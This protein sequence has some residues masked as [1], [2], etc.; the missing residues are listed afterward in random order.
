[1]NR[2]EV[3]SV[4]RW[5][6]FPDPRISS[7]VIKPR[8]FV[9]LG[10]TGALSQVKTAHFCTTTTQ[11]HHFGPGG[12]RQKHDVI[13]FQKGSAPFDADCILDCDEPPYS[14]A[15]QKLENEKN[16]E[17]KGRLPEQTMRHIYNRLLSSEG[18]S[19]MVLSDI[20]HSFNMAG[21]V[22]L[23]KP[24]NECRGVLPKG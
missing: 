4:F 11:A 15:L 20:H 8:W 23:K 9:Y 17:V 22:G 19:Y 5:D 7:S 10:E 1:L 14:D 13:R 16:I 12:V 3:G 24:N 18:Y 21:I 2:F 6:D